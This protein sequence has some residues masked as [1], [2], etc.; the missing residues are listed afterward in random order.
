MRILLL[1][2]A[3]V[4][5]FFLLRHLFRQPPR[6]IWRWA[7]YLT[8]AALGVLVAMGKLHWLAAAGGAL[9]ALFYKAAA[10]LRFAPLL[11]GL[12]SRFGFGKAGNARFASEYLRVELNPGIGA[13]DGEV[14]R[15]AFA[16]RRLSSM[17]VAELRKLQDEIGDRDRRAALLLRSYIALR[18]RAQTGGG[19]GA[20]AS[21]SGKMDAAEARAILGVPAEASPDDIRRAHRRLIQRLHPDRGGTDYLAAQVTRA[22]DVLLGDHA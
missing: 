3:L 12:I 6:V 19:T 5:A 2:A 15:G 7:L 21:A 8:V 18:T 4:A 20:G 10:V 9:L 14:L 17:S 13:L 22:R 11:G 1:I 16:G